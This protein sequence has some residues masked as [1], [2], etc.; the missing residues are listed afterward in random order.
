MLDVRLYTRAGCH[1]CE[2]VAADLTALGQP[3]EAV[4]IDADPRLRRRYDWLVPVVVINR[5]H[6]LVSRMDRALLA[7]TL[8]RA[9]TSC[10]ES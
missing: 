2:Q 3:F 9:A 6:V 10:A 8:A 7:A 5:R 4:D 1:L